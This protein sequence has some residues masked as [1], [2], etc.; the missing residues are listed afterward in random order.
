MNKFEVLFLTEAR[1]FLLGLDQK[2]RDKIIFNI[3]KSKIKNDNELF[4][5][6]KGEI[7]E[8]RTLYNKTYYRI[9]AFWDKTG[10]IPLNLTY[11]DEQA[12][13]TLVLA[14][15]GIIKKTGK[16]PEKEIEK[17]ENIRLKYFELKIKQNE[18]KV[19]KTS[20]KQ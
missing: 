19:S 12:K 17:A 16:T 20:K 1:E 14:T 7:W 6:L 10:K 4:K 3:D 2:S 9:F 8:F 13:Q 5:K 15:H 18:I 11:Q